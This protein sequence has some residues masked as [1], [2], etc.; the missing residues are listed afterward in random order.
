[1]CRVH[2]MQALNWIIRSVTQ[3]MC[4]H[5]L[6][7]WFVTSLTPSET[8]VDSEDDNKLQRK[9]DDQVIQVLFVY[10]IALLNVFF[11]I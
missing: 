9:S 4:L 5:D 10:C 11:R 3:P 1:M 2:A 6:L 8:D 7:W